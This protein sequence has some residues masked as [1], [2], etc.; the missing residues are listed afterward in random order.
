MKSWTQTHDAHRGLTMLMVNLGVRPIPAGVV[1]ARAWGVN[2]IVLKVK[3]AFK[4]G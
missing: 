4:G 3:S 2:E 1:T